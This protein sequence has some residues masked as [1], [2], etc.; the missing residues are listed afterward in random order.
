VEEAGG[1]IEKEE[2][3]IR[4]ESGKGIQDEVGVVFER[5]E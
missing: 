2:A 5:V 3:G 4:R 1:G